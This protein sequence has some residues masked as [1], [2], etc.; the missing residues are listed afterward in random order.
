MKPE[1][2]EILER[3]ARNLPV[4]SV[5]LER[6]DCR[7]GEI[8]LAYGVDAYGVPHGVW[9]CEHG[10]PGFPEGQTL[11]FVKGLGKQQIRQALV[12]SASDYLALC[13][14]KGLVNGNR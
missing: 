4:S 3:I 13:A 6:S 11:E 9:G 14:E 5:T 12:D 10:I 7:W 2:L 8:Y 1:S